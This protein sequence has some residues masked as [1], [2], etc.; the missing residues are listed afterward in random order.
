MVF[1]L[2]Y[3]RIL[4][5]AVIVLDVVAVVIVV[6][7]ICLILFLLLVDALSDSFVMQCIK[8]NR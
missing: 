7:I 8:I 6:A 4:F 1:V 3:L 2:H 5:D